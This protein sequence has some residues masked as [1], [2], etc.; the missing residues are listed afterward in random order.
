MKTTNTISTSELKAILFQ[1]NTLIIDTRTPEAYNGWT[2]KEEP[3]GGHIKGAKNFP[4]QWTNYHF[5]LKDIL[6]EKGITPEKNII[7]Y[8]YDAEKTEAFAHLLTEA[9]FEE[10]SCY[11]LFVSDWS[12]NLALPMDYLP[13]FDHLVSP[14]WVDELLEG[15]RPN[16]YRGKNFVI[17]HSHY[18]YPE[19]YHSGHIPGAIAL[20]TSDLEDPVTW[21][22]RTPEELRQ[23][24]TSH[25][26][27]ADTTVVLYGKFSFP[28]N[29][30]PYPGQAAGHLGAMRC[31]AIL[32]YAGV[33]DV[34]ILNGGFSRWESAGFE[35]STEEVKPEPL[36]DFGANIPTHPEYFVDMAEAKAMIGSTEADL[37]SIRSWNE[38]IGEVSGYN[39]IEQKGRIPGAVFGNCGTDAYHMEN[40]RNVDHTTREFHE[41][42]AHWEKYG[43]SRDKHLAF[44]C[45][46]GWRGSEA[47]INAY[48]MGYPK[49]S[50]Y[51][52]GWMEWSSH[53]GNPVATGIPKEF[54]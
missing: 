34:K 27:S 16:H 19:A 24:L 6:S 47:F 21:N 37:V 13:R 5:E 18:D 11:H 31:A 44:Y 52:G 7:L 26:I 20:N 46:T 12:P 22:R 36:E 14:Q 28:D 54:A 40:Y 50:V 17:A 8:G 41:I 45:G 9:G 25:G 23:V 35:V 29:H 15:N 2:L 49:I 53:P 43:I 48:L 1:D 33:K 3:R 51:D 39:Y 10:V 4:Y 32:L 42:K 38:I 30:D